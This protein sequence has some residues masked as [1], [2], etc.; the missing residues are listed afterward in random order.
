MKIKIFADG[1]DLQSIINLSKNPKIQGFTT[2]PTLMK[3]SGITDYRAFSKE[4][5]KAVSD[6]PFSLEVFSDDF[7][8]MEKQ[9][10]EIA[11]WGDNVYVKVPITNT[12]G[13]SS[14]DL[15]RLLT[16]NNIKINV[17]AI[18]TLD[19]V[20]DAALALQGDTPSIIS[21]F[22]G[23][24]ADSGINPTP[25][26]QAALAICKSISPQ[27][28]LLWASPRELYN[29]VEADMIGTHIITM[30]H[31][32]ISKLDLIGK[33]L[34]EFSLDTVKMFRNDSIKSGFIL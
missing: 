3:K 27:I 25:I 26:M 30:S 5:L 11:S 12:Q 33:D 1:A 15:I 24:I 32:L 28:E 22:A 13:E 14:C 23:R 18:F 7:M 19:Q 2:N 4:A 17:T 21:I 8:E 20:I 31:D 10:K 16:Y 34:T 29:L 6:K 9:A